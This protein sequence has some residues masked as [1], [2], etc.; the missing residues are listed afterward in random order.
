MIARLLTRLLTIVGVFCWCISASQASTGRLIEFTITENGQ[1]VEQF[2]HIQAGSVFL[3]QAGGDANTDLLFGS[4]GAE[5][6]VLVIIDHQQKGYYKIDDAAV[7]KAAATIESLSAIAQGQ[8]GV[9]SDLLGT[10]G[11]PENDAE[12]DIKIVPTDTTRTIAGVNCK[13][14]QQFKDGNLETDLCIA[15]KADLQ[16]LGEHLHTLEIFYQFSNNLS[17]KAGTLLSTLG[18]TMPNLAALNSDDG[19][20]VMA[21]VHNAALKVVVTAIKEADFP[22]E[23]FTIPAGYTQTSIPF[24]N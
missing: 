15:A 18:M 14:I 3:K 9:L 17:S 23:N 13:L 4:Q 16:T 10:L 6:A 20:P 8:K 7:A 12:V 2:A 11:L 24:I 5:G 1:V 22:A 21:Y 19:L